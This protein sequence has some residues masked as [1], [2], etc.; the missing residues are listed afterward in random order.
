MNVEAQPSSPDRLDRPGRTVLVL[1]RRSRHGRGARE[2]VVEALRRQG[3][4]LDRVVLLRRRK[5]ARQLNQLFLQEPDLS[6]LIVGGGD[7]T[8][9]VLA[10]R[11][12]GRG[13]PLGVIPLGTANDFARTLGIPLDI[14]DAAEVAAGHHVHAVDMAR[15]NDAY[16]LNV[17]S[18]G[19]SVALTNELSPRL[20]RWLGPLAYTIAG[21]R[22]FIRHPTFRARI[23]GPEQSLDSTVHQVVVANGR[24]YGGGVLVACDATLD[25]GE[26]TTYA[27]GTRGR[28]ELLRTI[29]LLRFQVPLNCPGDCFTQSTSIRVETWPPKPVNLD[30]EIRTRTP[31][32][33]V[34]VPGALRVLTLEGST[35]GIERPAEKLTADR[36]SS[37]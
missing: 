16:F 35:P 3:I 34:V 24:F 29:A 17:A 5:M 30:G 18:I 1:N 23:E 12:A 10:A 31:V 7:G 22:A 33:F 14:A 11:L 25:D 32:D 26:L 20:K 37:R 13:I 19:M 6:R 15:A 9:G 4:R 21:A 2:A 8:L 27:L 28:W 36:M